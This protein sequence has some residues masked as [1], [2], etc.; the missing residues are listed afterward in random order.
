MTD[1]KAP[2]GPRRAAVVFIFITLV[3]DMFALGMIIPVLPKLV[4][5][6]LGGNT[7]R[8]VEIFG[9]FST[10][11]A[12]MQFVFSPVH[13]VMSP[14]DLSEWILEDRLRVR[15]QLQIH[16]HIWGAHVRGV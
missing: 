10:A 1:K 8:A 13:G 3:L 7:A 9:L 14:K 16:K 11:W 12:L 15:L 5:T 4:E 2:T 6:F